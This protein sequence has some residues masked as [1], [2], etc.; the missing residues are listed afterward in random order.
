VLSAS[1][2]SSLDTSQNPCENF[3]QFATGNWLKTHPIPSDKGSL[4]N[5]ELLAQDNKRVIQ[6]ILE[7]E[8]TSSSSYDDHI[9]KKLRG[10]YS[11]CMSENTLNK[12]G[13]K[14]LIEVVSTVQKLYRGDARARSETAI[15]EYET[16]DRQS[17]TAALAYLHSR[18]IGALFSFDID[19]DVGKDPNFM[20]L[21]FGQPEFGLP[22][23]EY[24][25]EDDMRELYNDVIE[26]LLTTIYEEEADDEDDYL[27]E[28]QDDSL[29]RDA[30]D[31]SVEEVLKPMQVALEAG[32]EALFN[33]E[34]P[35]T[36]PPWPW[37]P[38]GP[39]QDP[40]TPRE[41]AHRHAKEVVK[42]ERSLARATLDLDVLYGDP[43]AT[44]NPIKV[45]EFVKIL[46]QFHF[47]TYLSTFTPRN[48]PRK[49]IVTDP[50]YAKSLSKIL[51]ETPAEIIEA[52]LVTRVALSLSTYLGQDTEL[53]KA[54]RKLEEELRGIKKGAVG[55]RAE[56][57]ISTVD[58]TLGFA[59]G[60]YFVNETFTGDSKEI[61]TGVIK[62]IIKTFK[63]SL[64]KIEWMDEESATAAAGK[65]DAIRVKVGYPVSPNTTDAAS[66]ATYYSSVH[67][68]DEKFFENIISASSSDEF[69]K[70]V[71]LGKRRDLEEW[72]M[73]PSM[74][75]AYFNPPA[76]EIVF[77][78]G[79]MRPPFFHR[80]WPAYAN[81]GSF[82]MVAAHELTHAFDSSGR[83]Y[84]QEGKLK[85][86][87]TNSTS[88]GFNKRQKCISKQYSSYTIDD[89]KGGKL[90]V[91][92]E[93][94]STENIGDTGL[95]QAFRAWKAQYNPDGD[96][97]LLP[98]LKFTR[99]QLFFIS[100]AR[101]WAMNIK[102]ASA[103]A[104]LRS[105][106]HSPNRWR[107]DGTVTN[108]PEFG[109]AFNCPIGTK[110]N[111]QMKDRCLLW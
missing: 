14:P 7:G 96:D 86:W 75:N 79:I 64:P 12:R 107:V 97:F 6:Q 54:V 4:G 39:D 59:S 68:D 89:G 51:N 109:K 45:T 60:R 19:G 1:V 57:C 42:F 99:E 95:I 9:L 93:L 47:S 10:M 8:V 87:W 26:K 37:P 108:I 11:S 31:L 5:F 2:L 61:G 82:G 91:N 106:P 50:A 80:N 94:T 36:W 85:E 33:V 20:T 65:A 101:A 103:I 92:G 74:V 22:S 81:Y 41:R 28:D 53:W 27:M 77:P 30:N 83:L 66:I 111:P 18:S 63:A 46:P 21:W 23:K 98:G 58:A 69:K 48:F 102:P 13:I 44:Y 62:D 105:D 17:L 78:A 49:I 110:L 38:W 32:A 104:R 35:N 84:N 70:W 25:E 55:D 67:I 40:Q 3:Y 24:Y 16:Q 71:K 15:P 29:T 73:W 76:N 88:D 72:E 43:Y 90:P 56:F 52:Y 34:A 100:F